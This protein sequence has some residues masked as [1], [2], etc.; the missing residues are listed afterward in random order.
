MPYTAAETL[1]IIPARLN[2]TRLPRKPLLDIAGVPMIV[3]VWKRAM[4]SGAG[5]VY[6]AT[7]STEIAGAVS[8][9]GGTAIVTQ[10]GHQSGSDR[11][12][13]AL[14]QIDPQR[15]VTA[16]INLQGD[17]P[18]IEPRLI[19]ECAG[20][21]ANG[22]DIGT[23][24]AEIKDPWQ[25]LDANVVKAIASPLPGGLLNALYF[26]RAAAPFGPGPLYHHIGIYAYRRDALERFVGLPPSY[27]EKRERLEQLRALEAG[28]RIHIRVAE[29][30]PLGVDTESD[31]EKAREM[32]ARS[33]TS[34]AP[35]DPVA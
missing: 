2:A 21:L 9:A 11:I 6:V 20:A 1:I 5:P 32:I 25:A 14:T 15:N 35:H 12:F 26:T 18:T 17:L 29:T 7:D 24:A 28:M 31:L 16:V 4:E 3:H 19:A 8:A 22:A 34:F 33:R 10:A 23:L 30:V 27:L 13:E